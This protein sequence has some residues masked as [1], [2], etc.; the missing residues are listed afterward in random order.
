M[1]WW[2]LQ[3]CL[4]LRIKVCAV[5]LSS[6]VFMA[7][8]LKDVLSCG[9]CA[10]LGELAK[11]SQ[12]QATIEGDSHRLSR[13]GTP[14]TRQHSNKHCCCPGIL[15]PTFTREDRRKKNGNHDKLHCTLLGGKEK[16]WNLCYVT[17]KRG[18]PWTPRTLEV[19]TKTEVN[20]WHSKWAKGKAGQQHRTYEQKQARRKGDEKPLRSPALDWEPVLGRG[21]LN[22]AVMLCMIPAVW[23]EVQ[24]GPGGMTLLVGRVP[25]KASRYEHCCTCS[26]CSEQQRALHLLPE[27][28]GMGGQVAQLIK[29]QKADF[30]T[31]CA[32]A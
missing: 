9:V 31:G 15:T 30:Q 14:G 3:L 28:G 19:V 10:K 4:G 5:S 11:P 29:E 22:P 6:A 17:Q 21:E 27:V 32:N 20:K 2:A 25:E 1:A 7:T 12:F 16:G 13:P 26:T 18:L 8:H 23:K 24:Q